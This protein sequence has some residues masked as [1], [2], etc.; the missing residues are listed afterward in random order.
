M[1]PAAIASLGVS[2]IFLSL[3]MH[4]MRNQTLNGSLTR[5]S[6]VGI[7][8]KALQRSEAAWPAGHRAAAPRLFAASIV[9]Y[10]TG[11]FSIFIIFCFATGIIHSSFWISR[12]IAAVYILAYFVVVFHLCLAARTANNVAKNTPITEE[13]D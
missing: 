13:I 11:I 4:F 10:M 5:N 1:E 2:L 9:G 3:G 8:T 7:R 6:A 12:F